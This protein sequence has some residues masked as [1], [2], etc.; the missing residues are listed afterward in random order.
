[1]RPAGAHGLADAEG[2]ATD[3]TEH[4]RVRL[5]KWCDTAVR[6]DHRGHGEPGDAQRGAQRHAPVRPASRTSRSACSRAPATLG[7]SR[8]RRAAERAGACSR[9]CWRRSRRT[10]PR[11]CGSR[12]ATTA[13]RRR[14]GRAYLLRYRHEPV[15]PPTERRAAERPPRRPASRRARARRG[16]S[17]IAARTAIRCHETVFAC[18]DCGKGLDVDYDYERAARHFQEMPSS[19]RPQNIWRF[20]ELLPIVDASRAGAG[21][22][23]RRLHAP[24]PRRPARARSWG[25]SNLYLKDDS[26]SRPSLSY[27]DRVVAMSVARLL[28]AG[29][30]R[31]RLR[32]HRQRRHRGRLA[33]RQGGR[34]RLRVLSQPP[35]GHEGARLPRARGE[36]VP[37]RG[38]LRRSQ[39]P[40]P[41]SRRRRR[42]WSSRTSRCARSTPRAPRRRRSRSSSSSAGSAPEHIVTAAAGG[43][44]SSRMHKG[45]GELQL[46]GLAE[47]DAT[48]IHIAQPSGCNPIAT[49]ILAEEARDPRRDARDRRALAGDRRARRRLPGD[50]RRAQTRRHRRLRQRPGDLRRHRPAGREP[51]AS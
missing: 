39:P 28:G 25:S 4:L 31:D 45:L 9:S 7:R 23:L 16:W 47:T 15:K 3:T 19:E 34:R 38:Q 10:S 20:E 17:A 29:A 8:S 12:S 49:A 26:T 21:G 27:K 42:A 11:S 2:P 40:L 30:R 14:R 50:R 48:R 43:T 1:M 13:T 35:G 41:R 33:R 18:P 37:G 6:E 36:G 22:A 24:D 5:A 51:R 32:V 46:L 44:L